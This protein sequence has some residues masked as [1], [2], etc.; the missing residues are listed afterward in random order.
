MSNNNGRKRNHEQV[1]NT[2]LESTEQTKINSS[3]KADNI[4]KDNA[5]A[6]SVQEKKVD[7]P[8]ADDVTEI[9]TT[10][11]PAAK[12]KLPVHKGVPR[13]LVVSALKIGLPALACIIV[14]AT[15]VTLVQKKNHAQAEAA[16]MSTEESAALPEESL[17]ENAFPEL[18]QMIQTYYQALADGD[19]EVIQSLKDYTDETELITFEKKSE[20]IESYN[21]IVCYTKSG[22]E[23]NTYILYVAYD[24]KFQGIETTAPGLNTMYVYTLE[25][26][27]LKIDGDMDEGVTAALKLVSNQDDVVDL[28]NKVDVRYKEAVAAD[29]NLN[30]F[31]T[32]LPNQIKTSVGIAL[33]QLE[34]TGNE[35]Q[36]VETQEAVQD[37]PTEAAEQVQDSQ[38]VVQESQSVNQQV[39]ATSTVNVRASDSEAADRIGRVEQGTILNRT[40]EKINGWSKVVFEDRE[41]YIKSDYLEVIS[42]EIEGEVIG[43]VTATTNVNVRNAA[44]QEADKIGV[45]Q[46]DTSYNLVEDMGE[47]YKI[48]YDGQTGYVK[49][50]Y[51]Q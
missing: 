48:D 15:V 1:N 40:E 22:M 36:E 34:G 19:K 2:G 31:L 17:Q 7:I 44:D 18:N 46:A 33:A 37:N 9:P 4:Q 32:E 30:A 38:S 39:R 24:V 6:D 43:T 35:T 20:Y 42:S 50:E 51:F 28:F 11:E 14:I 8:K 45:A 16:I 10:E 49:A 25:D 23:E 5:Q 21:N 12:S 26:G 27:T 47:W 3:V 29:E 41:A 13:V